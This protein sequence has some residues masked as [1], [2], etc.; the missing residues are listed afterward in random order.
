MTSQHLS[1]LIEESL[2][3]LSPIQTIM[4]MAEDRNIQRLG[5]KPEEVISFGGG[6]CNHQ[7]PEQLRQ[8]YQDIINDKDKFH[9]SGRYS[10]IIGNYNC[11]EQLC[12][13]EAALFQMKHL[14]PDHVL[15]GQSATQ[16][17][18]DI[19]RV[20]CDPGEPVGYLDPTYAN[21]INAQKC[22]LPGSAMKFIPAL[23]P[24]TWEYLSDPEHSLESLKHFTEQGLKTVVLPLADNP[25]SQLPDEAFVKSIREI[26]EDVK[27]FLVFDIPYKTLWF[28]QMPSY[29]SW[30][31]VDYPNLV[32]LNSNSKWLSSLGRRFGWVI[33]NEHVIQGFEKLSESMILS[34]D[35][36]HSMA[37]AEYLKQGLKEKSL[38]QYVEDTR[39]LYQHTA[40]VFLKALDEH[41]GWPRLKPQGG[42]YTVCPTPEHQDSIKFSETILATTGVLLIPGKG[43]GPSMEYGLRLSFGPL[44][45]DHERIKEGFERIGNYLSS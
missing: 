25:T 24:E 41:L 19:L 8:I 23:D 42:L 21:Y 15:L 12:R 34:P 5:L 9:A 30:D 1:K 6:W 43:F 2:A 20:L 14:H 45:Y 3:G 28:D 32:T 29:F 11:R 7:A 33:A 13:W 37:T 39:K 31:P 17:F 22:A 4:K 38:Q 26:L 40:Q 10:E 16:L 18:H 35:T 27:G 44:C 36:L